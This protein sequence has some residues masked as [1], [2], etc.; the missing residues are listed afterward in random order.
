LVLN[1]IDPKWSEMQSDVESSQVSIWIAGARLFVTNT[2]GFVECMELWSS[3]GIMRI[4][5]EMTWA[6][7]VR[8]TMYMTLCGGR[9]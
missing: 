8:G 6:K 3:K 1:S 2:L 5:R 4:V 9:L 7:F